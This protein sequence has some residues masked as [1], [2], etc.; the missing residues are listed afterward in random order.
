MFIRVEGAVNKKQAF[1][2]RGETCSQL[3]ACRKQTFVHS[4]L[5]L[6][7][8][9]CIVQ[10]GGKLW[11]KEAWTEYTSAPLGAVQMHSTSVVQLSYGNK[12]KQR[13]IPA[14]APFSRG[15]CLERDYGSCSMVMNF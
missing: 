9:R 14:C 12:S 8:W 2:Q 3:Y 5:K 6:F 13:H 7:A 1:K 11:Q 10:H 4:L 15:A